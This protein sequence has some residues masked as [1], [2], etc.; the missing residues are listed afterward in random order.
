[1]II[2]VLDLIGRMGVLLLIS[3]TIN[4]TIWY[5]ELA[6]NTFDIYIIS[7]SLYMS[8]AFCWIAVLFIQM[9]KEEKE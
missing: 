3:F 6:I 1:M 7:L 9:I 5:Q 8:M 4:R 2:K